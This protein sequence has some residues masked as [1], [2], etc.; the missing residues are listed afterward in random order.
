MALTEPF[1]ANRKDGQSCRLVINLAKLDD[2]Y[3]EFVVSADIYVADIEI[4]I[5]VLRYIIYSQFH[6][7]LI[8]EIYKNL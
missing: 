7:Y 8:V 1:L 5:S 4:F 2:I 6:F 3:P